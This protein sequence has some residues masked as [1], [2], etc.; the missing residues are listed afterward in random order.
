MKKVHNDKKVH[1]EQISII[2][3]DEIGKAS[4]KKVSY[5]ELEMRIK[6]E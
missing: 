3:L 5:K 6:Y 4:I 1:D 2:T